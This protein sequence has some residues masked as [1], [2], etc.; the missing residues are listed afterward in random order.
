MADSKRYT[1]TNTQTGPRGVQTA[2][3]GNVMVAPRAPGDTAV[4]GTVATLTED[5]VDAA[6]AAGLTVEA[7]G[8]TDRQI[9]GTENIPAEGYVDLNHPDAGEFIGQPDEPKRQSKQAKQAKQPEQSD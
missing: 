6:E 7:L 8:D 1:L 2:A 5:E 9:A 4:G 3:D